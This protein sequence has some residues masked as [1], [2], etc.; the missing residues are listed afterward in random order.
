METWKKVRGWPYEVSD[1]GNVRNMR[2][3]RVV[4]RDTSGCSCRVTMSH[5]GETLRAS[6]AR[7]MA[8]LFLGP[9]PTEKSMVRFLDGDHL[10]IV[11]SNI[12]WASASTI[13]MDKWV[14]GKEQ[15]GERNGWSVL[16]EEQVT[17]ARVAY[18]K[19]KIARMRVGF[20]QVDHGF[21]PKLAERYGVSVP[22]IK[23]AI[24]GA[25]WPHVPMPI[26]PFLATK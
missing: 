17:E 8:E 2:T 24:S 12:E 19:N 25:H 10:N 6:V 20:R 15:T 4:L 26:E 11:L 3:G 9:P 7:M 14:N 1:R 5:N 21:L 22:C 13:A 23:A 16:T 18:A